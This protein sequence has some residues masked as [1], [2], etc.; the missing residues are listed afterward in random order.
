MTVDVFYARQ[1]FYNRK[2]MAPIIVGILK[3][4]VDFKIFTSLKHFHYLPDESLPFP[5]HHADH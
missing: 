4:S 3:K 1:T 5:S 2:K